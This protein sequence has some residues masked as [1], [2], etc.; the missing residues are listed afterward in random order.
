MAAL[1][2][3]MCATQ[4]LAGAVAQSDIICTAT[5]STTPILQGAWLRAGTHLDL[6]GA[7]RPDMRE[8]DDLALKRASIFV[9]SRVTTI[10]HIGELKDPIARGV[11]DA[12]D[13]K[14]DFYDIASGAFARSSNTEITIAKNGGGAHLDLMTADYISRAWRMQAV[15]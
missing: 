14:A 5:M 4:D 7:Y 11:I 6:I 12:S 15:G 2:P 8:V 3:N 10:S 9:D 13:V 1:F